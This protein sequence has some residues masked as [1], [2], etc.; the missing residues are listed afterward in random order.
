MRSLL[1]MPFF[2]LA[3]SLL[4]AQRIA[5]WE[6]ARSADCCAT[7]LPA[8]LLLWDSASSCHACSAVPGGS[9]AS[10]LTCVWPRPHHSA[11]SCAIW[12]L[13]TRAGS[14]SLPLGI[15]SRG[16]LPRSGTWKPAWGV[17]STE[18]GVQTSTRFPF[19]SCLDFALSHLKLQSLGLSLAF[20]GGCLRWALEWLLSVSSPTLGPS[21]GPGAGP[22]QGER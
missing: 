2:L 11:S 17:F 1:R 12:P 7:P 14:G 15:S 13:G 22:W 19:T 4:G 5:V 8:H 3:C 6:E 9:V 16:L 18:H 21:S 10:C 20:P